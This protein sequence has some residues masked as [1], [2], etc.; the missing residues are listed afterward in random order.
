MSPREDM[1]NSSMLETCHQILSGSSLSGTKL[2]AKS[3]GLKADRCILLVEV[4]VMQEDKV[5]GEGLQCL[6]A[7]SETATSPALLR[8]S[9]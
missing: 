1:T 2:T 5:I 3:K 8:P 7:P 4:C 9:L 6:S